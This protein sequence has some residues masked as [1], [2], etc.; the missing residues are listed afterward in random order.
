MAGG[1]VP[2]ELQG[3]LHPR[4]IRFLYAIYVLNCVLERAWRFAQPLILARAEGGFGAIALLGLLAQLSLFAAGPAIG[5]VMDKAD[6][7]TTVNVAIILQTIAVVV[8]VLIVQRILAC[9]LPVQATSLYPALILASILERLAAFASD[10]SLERD[11]VV[12]LCGARRTSALALANGN[13]RRADQVSEFVTSLAVGYC[14][15]QFP[16]NTVSGITIVINIVLAAAIVL[17]VQQVVRISP[18]AMRRRSKDRGDPED[19]MWRFKKRPAGR[20]GA[21][22]GSGAIARGAADAARAFLRQAGSVLR[23]V[24]LTWRRYFR[25]PTA[26]TSYTTVILYFNAVL[27]PGGLMTAYLTLIGCSGTG[28][29]IFRSSCA[30]LGFMGTVLGS[31][32]ITTAG[33]LRTGMIAV[34]W[35][36]GTLL[37]A[38]AIFFAFLGSPGEAVSGLTLWGMP[39]AT[40]LFCLLVVISRA[41]LWMF[42]MAHAQILQQNVPSSEMSSVGG[43]ELSFCSL[44]ELCMLGLAAVVADTPRGFHILVFMSCLAVLSSALL[45]CGWVLSGRAAEACSRPVAPVGSKP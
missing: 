35:Q 36:S 44:A 40:L 42:D 25:Q 37:A 30:V 22:G 15:T 7:S 24:S 10:V 26:I 4:S 33:L 45:F 28:A 3:P 16:M 29:A 18:R 21:D 31:Y 6:R 5:T 1:A 14:V 34:V 8:S 19:I 27:A 11:W 20:S 17:L 38:G 12:A 39:A 13:L 41:G 9:G 23:D 43:V 32:L 2:S